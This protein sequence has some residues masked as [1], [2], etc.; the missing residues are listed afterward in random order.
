M[1]AITASTQSTTT[2]TKSQWLSFI[3]NGSNVVHCQWKLQSIAAA[4]MMVFVNGGQHQRRRR[5]DG[6]T[7]TQD[8]AMALATMASLANG[9]GGDGSGRRQL[10]VGG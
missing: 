5:W 8:D 3:V 7:M 1:I 2:A 6:G 4:A 9:G 10:C